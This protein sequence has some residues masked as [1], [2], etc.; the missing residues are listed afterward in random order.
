MP[1]SNF[2]EKGCNLLKKQISAISNTESRI[3]LV[4]HKMFFT[5]LLGA[6]YTIKAF[7]YYRAN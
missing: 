5:I 4:D 1:G 2:V 3:K 6:Y 7:K